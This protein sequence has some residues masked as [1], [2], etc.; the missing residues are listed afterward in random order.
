M[1]NKNTRLALNLGMIAVGMVCMAFAAVP[2]YN[3]FCKVTGFGGTPM[4]AKE[5]PTKVEDRIMNIRFNADVDPRLGWNFKPEQ[6]SVKVRVGESSL[7]FYKATNGSET[8]T[9]TAVYNVTPEKAAKYFNKVECFCFTRQTIPQGGEAH[10]PVSFFVDPEIMN[11][12]YLDDVDTITL[13]YTFYLADEQ[14][15]AV[16]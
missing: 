7:A 11:D 14:G 1:M 10:F 13:S 4:I 3:I 5:L 16:K 15:K 8:D 6:N 12:P 9:G 2:L